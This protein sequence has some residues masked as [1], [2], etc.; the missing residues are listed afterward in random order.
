MEQK[1]ANAHESGAKTHEKSHNFDGLFPPP[2]GV[3]SLVPDSCRS[4]GISHQSGSSSM[5]G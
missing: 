2:G 1:G 5:P 3:G 4:G